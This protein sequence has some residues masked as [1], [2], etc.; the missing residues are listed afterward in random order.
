MKRVLHVV[1]RMGYGGIETFLMNVYRNVNKNKI[2]FDFAVHTHI[3]GDYD[4]EIKKMGG[5]IY[6][7]TSRRKNIIKYYNDWKKFLK[8]NSNKYVAIHMHV[9]SLSTITPI[10]LSKR[11]KIKNRIIHAHSTLQEGKI[12]EFLNTKNKKRVNKYTTKLL[13]CSKTAGDYVF[14]NNEYKI[15]NNGI[16]IEK[17]KFDKNKRKEIRK[18]FDIRDNETVYINIGRLIELKNQKYLLNIFKEIYNKDKLSKLFIIGKGEL[19]SVLE[20]KINELNLKEQVILLENRNDISDILQGMDIFIL[21]SLY[22]GLPI[23]AIEA[24]SSGLKCFISKNVTQEVKV[25]DLVEFIDINNDYRDVAKQIMKNKNYVRENKESKELLNFDI[26]NVSKY[27]V[28]EI[29]LR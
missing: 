16:D 14:G 23:V 6:Y 17:F 10:V 28:N 26:K 19:K 8:E 29:Y 1:N 18:K 9:S 22:E 5:N 24:Q 7:F 2:Q 27:L 11:Y 12:H 21:P 3:P 25:T 4:E 20:N 15:V 13:A